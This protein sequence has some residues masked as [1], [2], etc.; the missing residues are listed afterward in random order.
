MSAT[1]D[2]FL[3][4]ANS[5]IT[6]FQNYYPF[7]WSPNFWQNMEEAISSGQITLMDVVKSEILRGDDELQRW[8]QRFDDTQLLSRQ[9]HSIIGKYSEVLEHLQNC[10]FY[11]SNALT[12]WAYDNVADG[13]LIAAAMAKRCTVVTF[14][15]PNTNLNTRYPSKQAK[16]PNVCDHFSIEHTNL[17]DMMRKLDIKP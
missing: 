11:K 5:L 1:P 13:W 9:D 6:P 2:S 4:D 16:I 8:I 3:I 15:A 17:F 12:E 14:E 7:D 10:G